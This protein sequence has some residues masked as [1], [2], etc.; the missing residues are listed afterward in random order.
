MCAYNFG[1]RRSSPTKLYHMTCCYVGVIM[2][3]HFWGD[4]L[5][6][7]LGRQ[8]TCKI[9]W[10]FRQLPTL[11]PNISEVDQVIKDWNGR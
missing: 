4:C 7:K 11:T 5:L 10:N 8:K 2:Q 1:S 3:V 6:K 9:R